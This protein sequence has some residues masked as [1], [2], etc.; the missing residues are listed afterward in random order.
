MAVDWSRMETRV[1][2]L[3]QRIFRASKTKQKDKVRWYQNQLFNAY[4]A[5]LLA[6][7]KVTQDNRGTAGVDGVKALNPKQRLTL[8]KSLALDGRANGVQRVY[9]PKPGTSEQRPLS[10]PPAPEKI[11]THRREIKTVI[12]RCVSAD[13]IVGRLNPIIRGWCQYY[14][15]VVSKA[16]FAKLSKYTFDSLFRWAQFKHCTKTES[17]KL[18]GKKLQKAV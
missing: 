7:R 6:L 9:I 18:I 17:T 1:L 12:K 10:I 11:K 14:Q 3:Q 8:A 16:I 13:Q 2:K 15:T 4:S 5:K